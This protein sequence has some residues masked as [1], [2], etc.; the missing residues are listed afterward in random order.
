MFIFGFFM[1][2]CF[3]GYRIL[4][5]GSKNYSNFLIKISDLFFG[6]LTG[7]IGFIFL[8]FANMGEIRF[9]IFVAIIFGIVVY[10]YL[11]KHLLL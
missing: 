9:Y 1:G 4:I 8:L 2:V 5:S 11:R 3:E 10:L 6:I 7:V